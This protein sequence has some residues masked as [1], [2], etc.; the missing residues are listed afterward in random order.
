MYL[1]T[2]GTYLLL[3]A[4]HFSLESTRLRKQVSQYGNLVDINSIP[5]NLHCNKEKRQSWPV[6]EETVSLSNA[7]EKK[8]YMTLLN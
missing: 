7:S 5:D 2:I 4:K 6:M 1:L 8:R 3:S